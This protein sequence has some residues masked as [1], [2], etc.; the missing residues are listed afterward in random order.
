M[1][2]RL[3]E[4]IIEDVSPAKVQEWVRAG[5]CIL[6]L[7]RFSRRTV[8][9][10]FGGIEDMARTDFGEEL[11]QIGEKRGIAKGLAKGLARGL[12]MSILAA[13]DA[14]FGRVSADVRGRVRAVRDE[15]RLNALLRLAVTAKSLA[16]FEARTSKLA[17]PVPQA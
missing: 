1:L 14:R 12:A 3:L 8:K 2:A 17:L 7:K 13:L 6:A 16:A 15:D 9:R 4:R 11:I 10:V 5:A